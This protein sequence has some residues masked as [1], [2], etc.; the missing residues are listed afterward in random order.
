VPKKAEIAGDGVCISIIGPSA[1]A[2]M[3]VKARIKAAKA[4]AKGSESFR[5]DVVSIR[6]SPL[7]IDEQCTPIIFAEGLNPV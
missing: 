1:R 2:E 3:V 6:L 4:V 5:Q 7:L